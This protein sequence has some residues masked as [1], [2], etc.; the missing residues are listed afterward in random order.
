MTDTTQPENAD[1]LLGIIEYLPDATFVINRDK[2]V[3][4]WNQAMEDMTG[5]SKNDILGEG[6][7]AYGTPFFGEPAPMLI[8]VVEHVDPVVES[9]YAYIERKGRTIHGEVFAPALFGGKGAYISAKASVLNNSNGDFIGYIESI[10]DIS[11]CKLAERIL[12][13][14]ENRYKA[15]FENT[16]AATIIVEEDTVISLANSEFE[17]LTGYSK[18]EIEGKKSWTEFVAEDD[19]KKMLEQHR[20]RRDDSS[21]ALRTY[22]FKLKDRNGHF[23]HI[24][25]TIDLIPGTRQTV[26]SLL[27]ITYRRQVE[28]HLRASEEKSRLLI[29]NAN[30]SILI[31]Q[32]GKIRFAN[33][34]L[35]RITSYQEDELKS[36]P[37]VDFIHPADRDMVAGYHLK[38]LRAE[39]AP[40]LY[41]FRIIDKD[42]SVKWLEISSVLISWE[43]R[44]A[45]LNFLIDI[46]EQKLY[47][48]KL[49]FQASLL[50]QVN[51]AV[52]ATD[53]SGTIT[54]WNRFA[55]LMYQWTE[56]EAIGKKLYETVIPENRIDK[57]RDVMDKI[58]RDGYY[59]G[60]FQVRRKDGMVF[61]AFYTFGILN[62]INSEM[63]GLVGVSMDLTERIK[64]END[65]QNK[66]I[67]LGAVAVGTNILLTDSDLDHAIDQTLELL[68]GAIKVDRIRIFENHS[69]KEGVHLADLRYSWSNDVAC[70]QGN[71]INLKGNR[72]YRVLP[73][74]HDTL[75][76]GHPIRAS[77]GSFHENEREALIDKEAKSLMAIPIIA[78]EQFWGFMQFDDFHSDR[79]WT[80]IE[81]TILQ[82]LAASIGGAI[83]RRQMERELRNAKE[84]AESAGK[85]K[86]EFLANMSHE[87]RT[88]MNAV[89]GL[90]D[91]MLETDLDQEQR[92]YAKTIMNSGEA[93]LSII[94]N[95]LD[96]SKIDS[97][98]IVL[99][100][101]AFG[102]EDCIEHSINLV[103][104][105]ASMKSLKL[106]YSIER[107]VPEII[108]GDAPKLS[109]ILINLLANAIKFTNKGG[110]SLEVAGNKLE[111]N[112]YEI[113]FA[114]KDTG[115]GIPENKIGQLFQSF[116][117]ID[118]STTRKSGGTGLGLA[119]SKKLAEVMGGKIWA[120]SKLGEGSTFHFTIIAAAAT[121]NQTTSSMDEV[122]P[123]I[124]PMYGKPRPLRI[125]LAE[126]NEVNQKVILKMLGKLATKLM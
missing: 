45:T 67:L 24:L 74:W 37:F 56:R 75:S 20:L 49:L 48:E 124:S 80:G 10:R 64:A 72:F 58:R 113:S 126:D 110:V 68:G 19:L 43:G 18:N 17:K 111:D 7:Y 32:D 30:E 23:K 95:I 120:E 90:I 92:D 122:H 116:S 16:G 39:N 83:A 103:A 15:I 1:L 101:K 98:R 54:Y 70:A 97:G 79:I 125:L 4:A 5:V 31:I 25:A 100:S 114:I 38:R 91:L 27:D 109:Q 40:Q 81:G 65:L 123:M 121:S 94:N 52:I 99:D 85:A 28:E 59:E 9:R 13:D 3:T 53:M 29:E 77:P 12:I 105:E 117:Q 11:N 33:P 55:E 73:N 107:A 22:E 44:P 76:K 82:A 71:D 93:L 47:E 35:M 112:N 87:I 8:D 42:G 96:F 41:D 51:N 46:T 61:H 2:E 26:G 6:D 78:N 108:I 104:R 62:N 66:D 36:R 86:S 69:S 21:R 63:V 50:R 88:P 57:M 106:T 89:I 60:E 84:M 102:I 34:K 118:T 115:M 14:S 119:I